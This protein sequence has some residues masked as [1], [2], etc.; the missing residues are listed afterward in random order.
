MNSPD[1]ETLIALWK[2]TETGIVDETE[3]DCLDLDSV[4][5]GLQM[6]LGCDRLVGHFR[7]AEELI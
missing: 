2:Q 5:M 7:L 3:E 6:E 4:R 1:V